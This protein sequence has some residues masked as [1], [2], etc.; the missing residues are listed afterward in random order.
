MTIDDPTTYTSL[1]AS[2]VNGLVEL[3]GVVTKLHLNGGLSTALRLS[4]AL[5]RQ[6]DAHLV[7]RLL[8]Q[9]LVSHW[10]AAEKDVLPKLEGLV[11]AGGENMMPTTGI[12]AGLRLGAMHGN[13][14]PYVYLVTCAICTAV[15]SWYGDQLQDMVTIWMADLIGD[16][17]AAEMPAYLRLIQEFTKWASTLKLNQY[18]RFD[19]D[20]WLLAQGIGQELETWMIPCVLVSQPTT[21]LVPVKG[22]AIQAVEM[23][24]EVGLLKCKTTSTRQNGVY[25]R[26]DFGTGPYFVKQSWTK[27]TAKQLRDDSE[28]AACIGIQGEIKAPDVE[29]TA[30]TLGNQQLDTVAQ[31]TWLQTVEPMVAGIY[32]HMTTKLNCEC[33]D[34]QRSLYATWVVLENSGTAPRL[35]CLFAAAMQSLYDDA[36]SVWMASIQCSIIGGT[37]YT[38]NNVLDQQ[39]YS[40]R[41]R[42]KRPVKGM[43][44][45]SSIMLFDSD[46][47]AAVAGNGSAVVIQSFLTTTTT[48]KPFLRYSSSYRMQYIVAEDATLQPMT[49]KGT[50]IDCVADDSTGYTRMLM[51]LEEST[52]PDSMMA[53][54]VLHG[55][56]GSVRSVKYLNSSTA[57]IT[58]SCKHSQLNAVG[59]FHGEASVWNFDGTQAFIKAH[60]NGPAR[61]FAVMLCRQ[62]G[63]Q[64]NVQVGACVT[65]HSKSSYQGIVT[66]DGYTDMFTS[67]QSETRVIRRRLCKINECRIIKT[68]SA[69]TIPAVM[70]AGILDNWRPQSQT[71]KSLDHI[72]KLV[73]AGIMSPTSQGVREQVES[74]ELSDKKTEQLFNRACSGKGGLYHGRRGKIQ[75]KMLQAMDAAT[76]SGV[77]VDDC[78]GQCCLG[79]W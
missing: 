49:P 44:C 39:W 43:V 47:T 55:A 73:L 61:M 24:N 64:H 48:T 57:P 58:I 4:K 41:R 63:I 19:D 59:K 45:G 51:E 74:E 71:S 69:D 67:L 62:L 5:Q 70:I 66:I 34:C 40:A 1:I 53:T 31:P 21:L 9:D 50:P 32:E 72:A 22:N 79:V 77:G 2:T 11:V 37:S 15:S 18:G 6:Q 52:A 68:T 56:D 12:M 38:R 8:S 35:E 29:L 16:I 23:L 60:K 36:A 13:P 25:I 17:A 33:G 46:I 54:F 10:P 3:P 14:G 27:R 28:W 76:T 65:C 26:N 78:A 7:Q 20:N 42:A 75:D 30:S